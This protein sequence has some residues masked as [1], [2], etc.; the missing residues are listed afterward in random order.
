V[1]SVYT[2]LTLAL[3]KLK[4]IVDDIEKARQGLI[5]FSKNENISI[6]KSSTNGSIGLTKSEQ[7][8]VDLMCEGMI[9]AKDIA[10]KL[11]KQPRDVHAHRNNIRRKFGINKSSQIVTY[12]QNYIKKS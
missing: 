12:Y 6:A 5:D 4:V 1:D 8:V 3:E 7:E 9:K 11:N 2:H 10:Q